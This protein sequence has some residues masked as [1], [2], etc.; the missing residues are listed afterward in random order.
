[1]KSPMADVKNA[2]NPAIEEDLDGRDI[3]STLVFHYRIR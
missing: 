3:I 1:M 2:S